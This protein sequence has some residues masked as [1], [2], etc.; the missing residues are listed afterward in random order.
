MFFDDNRAFFM[1]M[2]IVNQKCGPLSSPI[3]PDFD[4]FQRVG[5]CRTWQINGRFA[6]L[7]G[8]S[9]C[10]SLNKCRF[11][12]W[13]SPGGRRVFVALH[14]NEVVFLLFSAKIQISP[15]EAFDFFGA[16]VIMKKS[17]LE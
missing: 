1:L 6:D 13:F 2:G 7:C 10:I 3:L 5:F 14:Q 12:W 17:I 15:G 11:I 8:F 16:L 4:R 9:L